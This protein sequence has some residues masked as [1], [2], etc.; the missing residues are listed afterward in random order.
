MADVKWAFKLMEQCNQKK[1]PIPKSPSSSNQKTLNRRK[2]PRALWSTRRKGLP[3]DS[4]VTPTS[5]QGS[6][7]STTPMVSPKKKP[8]FVQILTEKKDKPKVKIVNGSD[9]KVTVSSESPSHVSENFV[10]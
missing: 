10:R 2:M 8:T 3:C 5:P 1:D 7:V 9:W 4:N 6:K